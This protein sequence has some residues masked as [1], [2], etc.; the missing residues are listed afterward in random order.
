MGI[1]I[2]L[3]QVADKAVSKALETVRDEFNS[4]TLLRGEWKF[5]EIRF[6][7]AVTNFKYQHRLGFKPLD[8][9]QT[10]KTGAGALTWNYDT[11]DK[12]YL[13]VTTTGPC[14]VRAFVG[15][16]EEQSDA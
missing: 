8:V 10:S 14:V 2:Q 12:D 11:F 6:T 1:Q 13:N 5:F 7:A 9:L 4:E 16:Y 3:D 15:R